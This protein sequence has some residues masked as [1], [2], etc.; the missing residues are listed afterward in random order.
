MWLIHAD[1]LLQG[2]QWTSKLWLV[3]L[4]GSERLTK[5]HAAGERLKEAQHINRSLSSLADCIA[6]KC[7]KAKH[8][9]YRN[10]KLTHLLQVCS[11]LL[12]I[13]CSADGSCC[14]TGFVEAFSSPTRGSPSDPFSNLVDKL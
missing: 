5:S 14:A 13:E 8:V 6:A 11:L 4:A 2:K 7:N 3:D 12:L 1:E 10:S 9:P